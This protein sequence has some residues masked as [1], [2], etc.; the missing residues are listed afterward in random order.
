MT[1]QTPLFQLPYLEDGQPLYETDVVLAQLAARLESILQTK[2][3][4]P[5]GASDLLA[6]ANRVTSLEN[7]QTAEDTLRAPQAVT[8]AT[9]FAQFTTAPYGELVKCWKSSPTEVQLQGMCM[10]TGTGLAV[11]GTPV[12]MFTLPAGYRPAVQVVRFVPRQVGSSTVPDL[13]RCN[14]TTA[15]VVQ[16]VP[17]VAV[18][19]NA[20]FQFETTFR[21]VNT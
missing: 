3:V 1:A 9:N 21:T 16:V 14:I 15:G 5:P 19:T 20:W 17:S 7:D 18:G 8:M 4:S 6:V 10:Y 12:S 11:S 2:A 13:F